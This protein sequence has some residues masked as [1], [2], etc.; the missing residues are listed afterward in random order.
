MDFFG[1]DSGRVRERGDEGVAVGEG[2]AGAVRSQF[3]IG[4]LL[5]A[6]PFWGEEPQLV[7]RNRTVAAHGHLTGLGDREFQFVV[8]ADP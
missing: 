7:H 2:L 3:L 8:L 5:L 6:L 1:T 4:L